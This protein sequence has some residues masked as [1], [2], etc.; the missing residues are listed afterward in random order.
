MLIAHKDHYSGILSPPPRFNSLTCSNSLLFFS[1]LLSATITSSSE[2][3]DRSGSSLEWSKD[4]SL[5][6]SGRHGLAQS[7]R[8][9]T[10]SPVAEEDSSSATAAPADAPS[11]TDQQHP[12][13]S[14]GA[15]GP[16]QP[17][18]HSPEGPVAYPSQASSSL[19]MPRPNSV[20]G[21]TL[22]FLSSWHL[23]VEKCTGK[24]L[25]TFHLWRHCAACQERS[26]VI[27]PVPEADEWRVGLIR[28]TDTEG[29]E[30]LR[31][32]Q[33]KYE[34][35]SSKNKL[36]F[37]E[38]GRSS[39]IRQLLCVVARHVKPKH[40]LRSGWSVLHS[41]PGT[42]LLWFSLPYP[43]SCHS[44][45]YAPYPLFPDAPPFYSQVSLT[46]VPL[47]SL[48]FLLTLAYQL[49]VWHFPVYHLA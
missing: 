15:P 33:E 26:A 18:S 28:V 16:P 40:A 46:P 12:N 11:R 24:V 31:E 9:D 7:V 32:V 1:N 30:H 29:R 10:C 27:W 22:C 43:H 38:R 13:T 44:C 2:N 21:K 3:D 48:L 19:M 20:A 6:G 42:S 41:C 4:G 47:F 36:C 17:P 34:V 5:R 23:D 25:Y 39:G 45:W 14:A 49:C 37:S 35:S 8:A